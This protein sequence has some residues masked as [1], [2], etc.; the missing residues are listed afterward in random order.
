MAGGKFVT[1]VLSHLKFHP[2]KR[3]VI[4]VPHWLG[5]S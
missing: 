3:L 1:T 4:G 5:L 2:L